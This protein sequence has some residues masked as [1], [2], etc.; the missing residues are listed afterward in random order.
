MRTRLMRKRVVMEAVE[1]PDQIWTKILELGINKWILNHPDICSFSMSCKH[2][3]NL[4]NQNTLWDS[5]LTLVFPD[6]TSSL[7]SQPLVQSSSLKSVYKYQLGLKIAELLSCLD[8]FRIKSYVT[9][10]RIEHC[11]AELIEEQDGIQ[12][13]SKT[14]RKVKILEELDVREDE[15]NNLRKQIIKNLAHFKKKSD[16]CSHDNTKEGFEEECEGC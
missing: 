5:L 4:S 3:N 2:F 8:V 1:I 11:R 14:A 7:S 13:R 15:N 12:T 16:S 9:S 10:G 6:H